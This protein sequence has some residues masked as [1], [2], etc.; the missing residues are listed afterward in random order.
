[1]FDSRESDD[2]LYTL[3]RFGNL[4]GFF[5][6]LN[7]STAF[8]NFF[9][10]EE[11]NLTG[12]MLSKVRSK[13]KMPDKLTALLEPA[14]HL[15]PYALQRMYYDSFMPGYDE[16][17][18]ARKVMI[19]EAIEQAIEH[20][21]TR[22]VFINPGFCNRGFISALHHRDVEH[23]EIDTDE[24]IEFKKQ[25]YAE[26]YESCIIENQLGTYVNQNLRLLKNS[27]SSL[28][29]LKSDQK[30]LVVIEALTQQKNV[31]EVKQLLQ[32]IRNQI[33]EE[34][35]VLV[36]FMGQRTPGHDKLG[37]QE[38]NSFFQPYDQLGSFVNQL[39]WTIVTCFSYFTEKHLLPEHLANQ[40]FT[41]DQSPEVY[42][43]LSPGCCLENQHVNMIEEVE[44]PSFKEGSPLQ[45]QL[46]IPENNW[47]SISTYIPFYTS[48]SEQTS[49]SD[50]AKRHESFSVKP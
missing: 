44:L 12:L 33:S 22:V 14:L 25:F 39:G 17:I 24:M 47:L 8:A 6:H 5:R 35:Q 19:K 3:T 31:E 18:T 40:W 13:L 20:N 50:S 1:M 41:I 34:S 37:F 2:Y 21:T 27:E 49:K 43:W 23:I 11:K 46:Q 30:T 32:D 48:T 36:G 4:D 38:S 29:M 26:N 9:G 28:A 7:Q 45:Q 15:S 10:E 16:H 42:L